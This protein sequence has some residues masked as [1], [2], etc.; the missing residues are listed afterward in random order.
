MSQVS[1]YFQAQ[2]TVGELQLWPMGAPEELFYAVA[3][4]TFEV[5]FS[6]SFNQDL[7]WTVE[8]SLG[9]TDG[10]WQRGVPVGGGDRGDPPTDFDGSGE[11]YLTDNV[12]GNSDVDDGIT[13]LISPSMD[14]RGGTDARVHYGLWYT[15]NFGNDPN[16][17]LF[18]VYVSNND[19]AAWTLTETI[20]PVTPEGWKEHDFMVGEFVTLTSQV[21]V[22]FEAS[23]LNDGSVVEAGI[24]DFRISVYGCGAVCGDVDG[25]GEVSL[26]DIVYFI[27]YLLLAGDPPQCPEPYTSCADAN[28]DDGVELSDAVWLINYVLKSG[29]DPIC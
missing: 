10:A 6:D 12:D 2:T 28:G 15:N 24:D 14:L 25:D 19:G 22:R 13:W 29:L 7:G 9:L 18:K 27:N 17:D 4:E 16:N 21:K 26:T 3:A 8:N 1:F 20:G 23:D 5:Q 11:C